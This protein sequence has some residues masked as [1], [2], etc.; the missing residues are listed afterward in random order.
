MGG[1]GNDIG[2]DVV[3]DFNENIILTGT[4]SGTAAFNTNGI[5]NNLTASGI[6]D[7]F[8]Q[9]INSCKLPD[10]SVVRFVCRGDSIFYGTK[11]YQSPG[12]F[13][14]SES[15][16]YG[17]DSTSILNLQAI[18]L[19]YDT[20]TA[21]NSLKLLQSN[22][23]YQWFDC[24]NGLTALTGETNATF[25]P[26]SNG[27]YSAQISFNG[28]V[29]TTECVFVS[30]VG[31]RESNSN[32]EVRVFPNPSNGSVQLIIP[33]N[34][35]ISLFDSKGVLHLFRSVNQGN[36]QL[37]IEDLQSGIYI[38]Q[39]ESEFGVTIEKLILK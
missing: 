21:A 13:V 4:F 7:A 9:K 19:N 29:D 18:E 28:C 14:I 37:E 32:N 2:V 3:T 38:L 23:Q 1:T 27:F 36:L 25:T 26:V 30:V 31:L 35:E 15:G 12:Q 33:I 6:S 39:F 34:G 8:I 22:A 16:Q 10:D 24:S 20:S 17:C 5:T 11:Y